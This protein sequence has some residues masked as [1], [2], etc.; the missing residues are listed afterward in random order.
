MVE[1]IAQKSQLEKWVFLSVLNQMQY[2]GGLGSKPE[3]HALLQAALHQTVAEFA[4]MGN[5]VCLDCSG[6][7]HTGKYCPTRARLT[8]WCS[9]GSR[10]ASVIG[11]LRGYVEM[12]YGHGLA[13]A[14]IKSGV[15]KTP[16]KK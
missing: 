3:E 15:A 2:G 16:R 13:T 14:G 12:K 11:Q 1:S 8:R 10:V 9:S 4:T 6:F 7:G 5:T